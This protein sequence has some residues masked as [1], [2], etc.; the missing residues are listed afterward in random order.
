M[1]TDALRQLAEWMQGRR[2]TDIGYGTMDSPSVRISSNYTVTLEGTERT[3]YRGTQTLAVA[4]SPD[5]E[6]A[7][8]QA[9]REV[10]Q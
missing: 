7:I 6:T 3:E 5:L 4:S 1:S 2:Q 8:L 9:L 10:N